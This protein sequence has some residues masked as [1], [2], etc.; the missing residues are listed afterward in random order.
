MKFGISIYSLK[1]RFEIIL[2]KIM[3]KFD[4][5]GLWAWYIRG[6]AVLTKHAEL[7]RRLFQQT[8]ADINRVF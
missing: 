3:E 5:L 7:G 2:Q 4:L 6:R 8:I 1:I